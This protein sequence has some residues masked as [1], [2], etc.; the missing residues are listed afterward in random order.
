MID[1]GTGANGRR[2]RK[3]LWLAEVVLWIVA[4]V[5]LLAASTAWLQRASA[6]H[7]AIRQI[8]L[9]RI[10]ADRSLWSESRAAKFDAARAGDA[11]PPALAVL[12]I[13]SVRLEVA[14]FDGTSE[15][16][17][18]LGAGRVPGTSR[19]GERGNL[20]IAGHRDGFFRALKDVQVGHEVSLRTNEHTIRYRISEF[21]VV[22]PNDVSV[23]A[24]SDVDSL[25]L[26]T[27]YPFYFV[28]S[29]PQR[30]IVRAQ[31]VGSDL[32]TTV[33]GD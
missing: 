8:D 29:A 12:S 20:A 22:E 1:A 27:C 30:F 13:P 10:E 28:G 17:L 26:I 5:A 9:Q 11:T 23:L 16:M 6:Q 24:S 4:G 2:L 32:P 7:H 18:N 21:F 25:T 19:I 14:V 15:R 33:D 3:L 31:A